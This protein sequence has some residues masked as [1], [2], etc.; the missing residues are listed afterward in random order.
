MNTIYRVIWNHT[1]GVYQVCSEL[2]K[3]MTQSFALT[4]SGRS[5]LNKKH[6]RYPQL[7]Q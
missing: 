3:R 2:T 1:L 7:Q 5:E 6:N 4:L